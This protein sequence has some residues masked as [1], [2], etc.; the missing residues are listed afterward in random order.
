MAMFLFGSL[1]QFFDDGNK[2]T[3]RLMMNGVLLSHGIDAIN[4]PAK[5]KLEFNQRMITF[6]DTKKADEM[7][8][9]LVSL[10]ELTNT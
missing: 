1:N 6:Y 10:L 5:R 8:Q 9:F 3:S 7:I 2:R 4:V